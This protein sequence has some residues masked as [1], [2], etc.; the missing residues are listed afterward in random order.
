MRRQVQLRLGLAAPGYLLLERSLG[1]LTAGDGHGQA[2]FLLALHRLGNFHRSIGLGITG[3]GRFQT[4]R[5]GSMFAHQ[6]FVATL[7]E[8]CAA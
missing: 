7:V 2:G 5:A 8:A 3:G 6:A 1:Q 4:L